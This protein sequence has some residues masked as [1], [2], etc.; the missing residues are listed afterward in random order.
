[1]AFLDL[2]DYDILDLLC[3]SFMT[4]EEKGQYLKGY[5]EAFAGYMAEEVADQFTPDDEQKLE[6]MLSDPK[7]KPS[8]VE[9]FY[10]GKIPHYDS[11]ILAGALTFKKA[12]ILDFYRSML[13][14]TTKQGDESI[15]AWVKIVAAAEDDKWDQVKY[16]VDEIT[17]KYLNPSIAD[18]S[19]SH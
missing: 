1:M 11:F 17:K 7:T 15:A 10:R 19:T 13:E 2:A 14:D 3:S 9:N 16:L 4:D 12:F 8:E 6:S 18:S 5:M